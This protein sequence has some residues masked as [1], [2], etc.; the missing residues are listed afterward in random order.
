MVAFSAL[1]LLVGRQEGHLACKKLTSGVLAWLLVWSNEQ[2]S[3]WPSWCHCH[4]L[5]LASVKSWLVLPFCYRLTWVVLDKGPLNGC[6]WLWWQKKNYFGFLTLKVQLWS[7]VKCYNLS[8]LSQKCL[9]AP[10][11]TNWHGYKQ[12]FKNILPAILKFMTKNVAWLYITVCNAMIT[13]VFKTSTCEA[14]HK[15]L[16]LCGT[17]LSITHARTHAHSHTHTCL[18]A[19]CLGLSGW[20]T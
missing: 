12:V 3:I 20:A 15:Q 8:K 9:T 5:S 19:L 10:A 17:P 11:V 2:I 6:V 16:W 14:T 13:K 18:T 1:M 7:N 4:S